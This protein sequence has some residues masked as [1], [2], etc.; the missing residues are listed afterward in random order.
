MR[1]TLAPG[2]EDQVR[3]DVLTTTGVLK[4]AIRVDGAPAPA[5]TIRLG[6]AGASAGLGHRRDGQRSSTACRQRRRTPGAVDDVVVELWRSSRARQG[7]R[8]AH[9]FDDA[10]RERLR[11]LGYVE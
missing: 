9:G 8:P 7:G 2:D 6:A 4:L 11:Q 10:T 5:G 3:F 1:G